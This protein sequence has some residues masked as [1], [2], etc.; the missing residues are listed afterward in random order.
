MVLGGKVNVL[1]KDAETNQENEKNSQGT[2]EKTETSQTNEKTGLE[3][4]TGGECL[5]E[6]QGKS[7]FT[8]DVKRQ[9]VSVVPNK[10]R[11]ERLLTSSDSPSYDLKSPAKIKMKGG[12]KSTMTPIKNNLD[13]W[14][15]EKQKEVQEFFSFKKQEDKSTIQPFSPM[16]R[17]SQKEAENDEK[18]PF[19]RDSRS[20]RKSPEFEDDLPKETQEL[21]RENKEG[22]HEF[23]VNEEFITQN[24]PGMHK[25]SSILVGG[26]FGEIALR[27][28]VRRKATIL[29]ETD[30][31]FAILSKKVYEAVLKKYQ[32]SEQEEKI[33]FLKNFHFFNCYFFMNK[34][35]TL[36]YY[37][38]P[39]RF[40]FSQM[41]YK[42]GEPVSF[43]YLLEEGEIEVSWRINI[44]HE[45]EEQKLK[46]EK[47]EGPK[48]KQKMNNSS[49]SSDPILRF[50]IPW[51]S[52]RIHL[53]SKVIRDIIKA[54]NFFGE[55][56]ILDGEKLRTRQ[57][58]CLSSFARV[59]VIPKRQLELDVFLKE[60]EVLKALKAALEKKKERKKEVQAITK[61][62][63]RSILFL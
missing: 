57:A 26:S 51:T 56:E 35:D 9:G 30:C 3:A 60:P 24:F 49:D 17:K 31:E 19:T 61:K 43:F 12:R 52:T 54:P 32:E 36:T 63:E 18:S 33:R 53:Q 59:L 10:E 6:R 55:E 46:K 48:T 4:S 39:M 47:N 40:G 62:I 20:N 16:L 11:G 41:L 8:V 27:S 7:F 14:E 25:V 50:S 42:E 21:Q 1:V 37:F 23:A 44:A 29:C 58:R 13:K 15:R 2:R 28:N 22:E 45:E 5:K 34:I 38:N